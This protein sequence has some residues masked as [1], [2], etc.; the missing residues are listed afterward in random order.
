MVFYTTTMIDI[1]AND[2]FNLKSI[3]NDMNIENEN[4][5]S[6]VDTILAMENGDGPQSL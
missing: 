2:Q 6:R 1:D 3:C 4:G 5:V